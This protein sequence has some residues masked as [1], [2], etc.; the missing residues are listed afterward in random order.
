[1]HS[2]WIAH[3][4]AAAVDEAHAVGRKA[5]VDVLQQRRARACTSAESV[6]EIP[7]L[8]CT[9]SMLPLGLPAEASRERLMK[10]ARLTWRL[11]RKVAD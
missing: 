6:A 11:V 9:A 1:M 10:A 4:A 8:R 5:H 2:E 3:R 7:I